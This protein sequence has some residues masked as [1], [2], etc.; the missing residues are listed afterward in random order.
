MLITH[1]ESPITVWI[2][3]VTD[4]NTQKLMDLCE[5]LSA[6][7]PAAAKLSGPVVQGK[8]YATLFSEDGQWYR[9]QIRQSLGKLVVSW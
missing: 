4:E 6:L 7:C 8:I 9:C 1:C 5:Q 2:Q 3:T